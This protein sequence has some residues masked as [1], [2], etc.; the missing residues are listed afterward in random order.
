MRRHTVASPLPWCCIQH[1]GSA[2][3][4]ALGVVVSCCC[5]WLLSVCYAISQSTHQHVCTA[6]YPMMTHGGALFPKSYRRFLC[7]VLYVPR[8]FS[9]HPS[10]KTFARRD[11]HIWHSSVAT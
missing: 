11:T 8:Q 1:Y 7:R 3:V 10:P 2:L 4:T 9:D 6:W 5:Q